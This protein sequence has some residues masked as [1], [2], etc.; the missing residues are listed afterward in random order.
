MSIFGRSERKEAQKQMNDEREFIREREAYKSGH[1]EDMQSERMEQGRSDLIRWQQ[2][3][4]EEI[5]QLKH[6]L[7]NEYFDESTKSWKSMKVRRPV[8]KAG[9]IEY[10]E[11]D[12]PP[13]INEYG[14]QMIEVVLRPFLSRNMFNTNLTEDRI[15]DM[16]KRTS[17]TMVFNIVDHHDEYD[18]EFTNW[19]HI[20]RLVKNVMIPSP[21]RALHGWGKKMDTGQIKRVEAYTETYQPKK[22]GWFGV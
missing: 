4:K 5:E 18:A 10:K 22:K 19:D 21:F 3:F 9:R 20:I 13:L 17:N 6:D 8:L 16:L 2:D 11:F 14:I 7:R 12:M 15:L 1:H